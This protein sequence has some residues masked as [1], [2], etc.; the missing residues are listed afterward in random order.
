MMVTK[1]NVAWDNFKG[2]NQVVV[3]VLDTGINVDSDEL[4]GRMVPST[5]WYDFI[6]HDGIP[7][8]PT[9]LNPGDRSIQ[10][11]NQRCRNHRRNTR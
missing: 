1:F 2:Q 10:P 7:R 3:A 6:D 8:E 5:D 4:S 9:V 11:R